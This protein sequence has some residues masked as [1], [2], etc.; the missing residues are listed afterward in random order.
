MDYTLELYDLPFYSIKSGRK[1]VEIRLNDQSIRN[2]Q[3]DDTIIFVYQN[4]SL[5]TT[6]I[7]TKRY[8][9]FRNLYEDIPFADMDCEQ[10]TMDEMIEATY[11]FYTKNEEEKWGAVAIKIKLEP[12]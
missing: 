6:V 5:K 1:I 4:E 12:S 11:K 8:D 2:I 3:P 10:W 9:T 7:E